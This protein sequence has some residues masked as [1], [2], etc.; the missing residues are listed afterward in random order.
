MS[1]TKY[2]LDIQQAEERIMQVLQKTGTA[3]SLADLWVEFNGGAGNEEI[4]FKTAIWH[5]ISDARIEMT[6]DQKLKARA[7]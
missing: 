5:L 4:A 3:T 6:D 2:P 1:K 7:A